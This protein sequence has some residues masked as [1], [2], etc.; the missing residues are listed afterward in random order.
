MKVKNLVTM[1]AQLHDNAAAMKSLWGTIKEGDP[2]LRE[3]FCPFPSPSL[4]ALRH[5]VASD[6]LE[7]KFG[8]DLMDGDLGLRMFSLRDKPGGLRGDFL[9]LS[10]YDSFRG[11]LSFFLWEISANNFTALL[12]TYIWFESVM[13]RTMDFSCIINP[14]GMIERMTEGGCRLLEADPDEMTGQFLDDYLTSP[15]SL[16][17]LR[18]IGKEKD[19][20]EICLT[21]KRGKQIYGV[22]ALTPFYDEDNNIIFHFFTF[23]D[24]SAQ[25][26]TISSTLKLNMDLMTKNDTLVKSQSALLKTEKLASLGMLGAGLAHEI[27][28]PLSYLGNDIQFCGE[29][30]AS[31][32]KMLREWRDDGEDDKG[33]EALI[34]KHRLSESIEDMEEMIVEM[35]TGVE[36]IGKI[37]RSLKSFSG[38]SRLNQW[39]YE[40]INEALDEMLTICRNEYKYS[41]DVNT[42]YD[43]LPAVFCNITE[44]NQAFLAVFLNAVRA[45]K[46]KSY[47][48]G[49]RGR[50][51]ITTRY[52]AESEVIL[53]DITDDGREISPDEGVKIFEPFYTNWEGIAQTGMGLTLASD[54]I[55]LRHKGNIA[56]TEDG[57]K[58][59]RM[60][61]PLI[62]PIREGGEGNETQNTVC[63]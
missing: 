24:I 43:Q 4:N 39:N 44:L 57:T 2:P 21:G 62:D 19:N 45:V 11:E 42:D 31:W 52:D 8:K 46:E 26:G 54:I 29:I 16:S 25:M 6:G 30:A 17:D 9:L 35:R 36:K 49:S 61:L 12:D 56:L 55:V 41:L 15:G 47:P 22:G 3:I 32:K 38:Q 60:T 13:Q 23:T 10:D 51:E 18:M 34:R 33:R 28:N 7:K 20:M 63:R 14:E 50:I 59:F 1:M 37:V 5:F 53:V 27:N 40:N 58:T 48:R